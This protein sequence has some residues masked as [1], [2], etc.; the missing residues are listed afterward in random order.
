MTREKENR[1]EEYL[2][3]ID[4]GTIKSGIALLDPGDYRPVA[5][6][7]IPNHEVYDW[8]D[9]SDVRLVIIEMVA[10]YGMSVGREV[11]ETCVWI[12]RFQEYATQRD[13][14]WDI[15]YRQEE[16]MAIC[17]SPNANDSTIRQGLIDRFCSLGTTNHGKGTKKNPGWFYG[18]KADAWQAYAVGV[19]YLDKMKEASLGLR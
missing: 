11:F 6:G 8:I 12:G 3:A 15:I 17:H 18:F 13:K 19:T 5:S 16:K 7:K 10:S 9:R 2:L 4:P 1:G 14:S